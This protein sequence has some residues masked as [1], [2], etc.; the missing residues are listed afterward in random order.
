ML[1]QRLID[2]TDTFTVKIL[3]LL[4][5]FLFLAGCGETGKGTTTGLV[6][7]SQPGVVV[8]SIDATVPYVYSVNF[9][10]GEQKYLFFEEVG[11][12]PHWIQIKLPGDKK[13]VT[14]YG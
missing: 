12:Y 7:F 1:K 3:L 13:A 8:G 5:P 2:F 14:I 4:L 10:Y 11:S 6:T 9:E